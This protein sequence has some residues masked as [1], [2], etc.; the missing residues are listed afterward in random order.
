MTRNVNDVLEQSGTVSC[1]EIA[2]LALLNPDG[3]EFDEVQNQVDGRSVNVGSL[4]TSD[5]RLKNSPKNIYGSFAFSPSHYY[6]TACT[7]YKIDS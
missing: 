5:I 2:R 6:K 7:L 4:D 3:I 1:P